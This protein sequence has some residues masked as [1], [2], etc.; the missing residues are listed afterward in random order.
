MAVE[1]SGNALTGVCVAAMDYVRAE[2]VISESVR[3]Y[4]DDVRPKARGGR[5]YWNV[6]LY[7]AG[8]ACPYEI[9]IVE[10]TLGRMKVGEAKEHAGRIVEWANT[11]MSLEDPVFQNLLD[12]TMAACSGDP[13]PEHEP[14]D[15]IPFRKYQEGL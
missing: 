14:G 12:E 11:A 9:P 13:I 3:H 8:E 5:T 15:P 1:W 7:H 2:M 10:F 6:A 4:S